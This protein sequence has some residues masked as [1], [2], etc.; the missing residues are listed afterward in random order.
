VLAVFT[1]PEVLA[2]LRN[3]YPE[4]INITPEHV[5]QGLNIYA[6]WT[7]EGMAVTVGP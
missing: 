6:R 7:D 1:A 3:T 5:R 4:R 2:A